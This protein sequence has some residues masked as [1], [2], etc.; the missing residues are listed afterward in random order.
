M[1]S[2]RLKIKFFYRSKISREF[3]LSSNK[4]PSHVWEPQTTK[5]LVYLSKNLNNDVLIGGAYFGDQAILI[6]KNLYLRN[7]T[8][9]CFEPNLEQNKM[10]RNNIKINRIKYFFHNFSQ[11]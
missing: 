5:L 3:L 10:L 1:I 7:A 8:I 4:K 9:H 11:K 6:S 2:N